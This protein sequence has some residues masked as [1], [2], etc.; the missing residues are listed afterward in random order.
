M[1]DFLVDMGPNARRMVKTL[2]L[3]LPMP[4]KLARD[5]SPWRTQELSDL[6]VIVQGGPL[7]ATVAP[8]L[9]EAGANPYVIGD[10]AAFAAAGEAF[11][12]PPHPVTDEQKADALLLDATGLKTVADLRAVYDFFHPR[13]R[14]IRRCGRLVVLGR[15]PGKNAATAAVQQ[16]LV[17]FVKS[18]GRELGRVGATAQLIQVNEGAEARLAPVLRF[19][20]SPRS[21][22]ISGQVLRVSKT[23]RGAEARW[24]RPLEG[25]VAV[26]TGA[27]RGIGRATARA[28]ARE[29]AKVIVLDHPSSDGP[30]SEVT[31][32]VNGTLVL[33]DVT[34][35][36]AIAKI[37]EAAGG[38]I[39]ILVNNAGITRDKTL[40]KMDEAWWDLTMAVN[41]QAVIHL[42]ENLPLAKNA[43]VICLSSIA[44]ISGNMGQT[45]Y[46][47][48]KA[49][50]YGYVTSLG[51]TWAK[52][53]IAVNAIAPG[54]I[55]TRLT[56]AIP[57]ATREVARRL[58]N[59]S[60]GG[61]PEDIAEA[62]T[63]LASPGGGSLCGQVI[64]VCGGNF[65]GA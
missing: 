32:E 54:F 64:R 15:P 49:G 31:R 65:V 43:R 59:L 14:S 36:E 42:T 48:S 37:T 55:E 6:D 20:L 45:N 13:I 40:A 47:T 19:A 5:S 35:P 34:D 25:K 1:S 21:A 63:F 3:P 23:V 29:G 27:A 44:G 38:E 57:V 17:G 11:G 16:A 60:Q 46:A 8:I 26:V 53:G 24:T 50:V 33:V 2:G 4:Q 12:R 61:L 10:D 56:H 41:L 22:F 7:D 18:A 39:D 58:C 30:A 52:K 62:V 28:L 9:A 51:P